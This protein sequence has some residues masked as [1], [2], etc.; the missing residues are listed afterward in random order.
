MMAIRRELPSLEQNYD[1]P[2]TELD[3]TNSD[4]IFLSKNFLCLISV[5]LLN[6]QFWLIYAAMF[7]ISILGMFRFLS[8][9]IFFTK[10]FNA[11]T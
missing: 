8:I 1:K 9:I 11:N 10:A 5:L 3:H 7:L 4:Q 6:Y 2:K